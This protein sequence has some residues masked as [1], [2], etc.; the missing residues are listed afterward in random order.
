VRKENGGI[1]TLL[2]LEAVV[3][4]FQESIEHFVVVFEGVQLGRECG[5]RSG[6]AVSSGEKLIEG[7]CTK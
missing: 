3:E 5:E 6:N 1:G 2:D 4:M 7:N